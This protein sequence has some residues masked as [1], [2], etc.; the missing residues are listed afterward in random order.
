MQ[1]S[2]LSRFS[3][4]RREL[5]LS[6]FIHDI[7]NSKHIL[8]PLAITELV[9]KFWYRVTYSWRFYG[10]SFERF[11]SSTR[12]MIKKQFIYI[13]KTE[14][15]CVIVRKPETKQTQFYL[16][17]DYNEHPLKTTYFEIYCKETNSEHRGIKTF[18]KSCLVSMDLGHDIDKYDAISLSIY[19]D[20]KWFT[21][22][23]TK[24]H[25]KYKY[26]WRLTKSQLEYIKNPTQC[27]FNKC[28]LSDN[29]DGD[30][31]YLKCAPNGTD[32][33]NKGNVCIYLVLLALKTK[34]IYC[35]DVK[36]VLQCNYKR[37][38]IEF[39]KTFYS[40]NTQSDTWDLGTFLNEELVNVDSLI[41]TVN[42]EILRV[43]G[44]S[45]KEII[46][47]YVIR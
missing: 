31:W 35:M 24:I 30:H 27:T 1:E 8:I 5:L 34:K 29:F 6:G 11:C 45:G 25:K 36:Y 17:T 4:T 19:I 7:Y 21:K 22:H 10:S 3:Y 23:K 20:P 9:R 43:Y 32:L 16:K 44:D 33:S 47:D 2:K 39:V 40:I 14:I 41:F 13:N 42:I 37:I 18:G 15:E 38:A 12:T 28:I 26:Q 46:S